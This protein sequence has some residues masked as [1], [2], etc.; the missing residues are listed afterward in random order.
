MT[1]NA[2]QE[3]QDACAAAGT[4]GYVIKPITPSIVTASLKASYE[5]LHPDGG[6]DLTILRGLFEIIGGSKSDLNS[7]I[8]SFIYTGHELLD[9]FETGLSERKSNALKIAA[10]TLKSSAADFGAMSLSQLC[11]EMELA[12][13]ESDFERIAGSYPRVKQQFDEASTKLMDIRAG[14]LEPGRPDATV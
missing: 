8:N 4:N 9:Q 5:A 1:A 12:A 13:S 14:I 11:R 2:Q 6:L 7:L 3:T 10:H